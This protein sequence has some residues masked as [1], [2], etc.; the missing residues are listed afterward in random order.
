MTILDT[1][2]REILVA[3]LPDNFDGYP[4]LF[5]NRGLIQRHIYQ[6][7]VALG[8][9]FH[10]GCRVSNYF[11]DESEARVTVNGKE[12]TAEGIIACD[13]IHSCAREFVTGKRQKAPNSGFAIYRTWFSLDRLAEHPLTKR[14]AESKEDGFYIWIGLD[15]HVILFT[16]VAV[17]GCVLFCTH[18]VRKASF[19]LSSKMSSNVDKFRMTVNWSNWSP[20]VLLVSWQTC[21]RW[22]MAG[23]LSSKLQWSR[24]QKIN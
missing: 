19:F 21:S 20:G 15:T 11:E 6:H 2:G 7:A 13:G 17:R 22:L 24:R 14:S 12:I 23:T 9:K 5:S 4:V 10:F 3:P 18:K 16:S 8:V 1:T